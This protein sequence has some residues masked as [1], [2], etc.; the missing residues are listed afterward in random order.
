MGV[1]QRQV[2]V[3]LD[4]LAVDMLD[5][6]ADEAGLTKSNYIRKVLYEALGITEQFPPPPPRLRYSSP[7]RN[8]YPPKAPIGSLPRDSYERAPTGSLPL[9]E[10]RRPASA[11]GNDRAPIGSLPREDPAPAPA[12][13]SPAARRRD[14]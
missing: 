10:P 4:D 2:T 1:A 3:V 13:K 9:D 6:L 12:K 5:D 7:I 11:H 8:P 14:R